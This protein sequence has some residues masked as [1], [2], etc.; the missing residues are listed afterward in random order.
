MLILYDQRLP[1]GA[2]HISPSSRLTSSKNER[3]KIIFLI[4]LKHFIYS[5]QFSKNIFLFFKEITERAADSPRV[6]DDMLRISK[7]MFGFSRVMFEISKDR[8]VAA[9][10]R[11]EISK[12]RF[13]TADDRFEVSN[14]RF[15][16]AKDMFEVSKDR[17][18]AA[19]DMFEVSKD[20]FAAADDRFEVSNDPFASAKDRFELSKDPFAAAKGWFVRFSIRITLFR[21]LITSIKNFNGFIMGQ[22]VSPIS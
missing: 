19:K 4:L 10:D 11:F 21:G 1:Q 22:T 7:E 3:T 17:F 12:D 20:R 8:F 5:K 6:A 16:S 14:D 15:T 13:A 2:I 18:A 9:D